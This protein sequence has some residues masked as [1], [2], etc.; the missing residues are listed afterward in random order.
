[1]READIVLTPLPH[2][3]GTLKHRPALILR[4][5]PPFGDCLVCGISTQTHRAVPDFD[6]IVCRA[7]PDF[8]SSGLVK[9]SVIHFPVEMDEPIVESRHTPV[10]FPERLRQDALFDQDSNVAPEIGQ[11][12]IQRGLVDHLIAPRRPR[13]AAGFHASGG[14]R[15]CSRGIARGVRAPAQPA[16]HHSRRKS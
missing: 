8:C 12:G 4:E 16:P 1:M 9:D 2:A 15:A 13:A 7:D 3:D 6:E 10:R 14:I 11:H 5:F